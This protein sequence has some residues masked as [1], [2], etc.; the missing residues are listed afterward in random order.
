MANE[1][2]REKRETLA[3]IVA[4]YRRDYE[5]MKA[6]RLY[7]P[8]AEYLRRLLDRIEAACKREKAE[9][10][11]DALTVGGVVEASRHTSGNAA[12]ERE[13]L[14]KV[15]NAVAWIAESCN[16]QQTA[17]YMNDIIA[18]VQSALSAPARNCDRFADELNAQL[19]FLNEVWLISVDRETMLEQDKYENW[20]DEM[21]KRYGR[22][23]LDPAAER[24]GGGDGK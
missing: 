18:I 22:W 4:E 9:A 14:N 12:A 10:E 23:L 8:T 6:R 3:D 16:D 20:T 17:E 2:E 13:A 19:A 21:R 1:S 7:L 24:K 11:A 15:G 5:D